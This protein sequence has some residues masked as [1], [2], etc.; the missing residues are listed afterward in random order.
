MPWALVNPVCDYKTIRALCARRYP[1]HPRGCPNLDKKPACPPRA[2]LLHEKIDL[3]L[4]VWA[5]W[6]EY[7]IGEHMKRM[8]G[9]HPKWSDRQLRNPLYWQPAARKEL[10][11]QIRRWCQ[12]PNTPP[13]IVGCP[14]ACGCN[15]TATMRSIG[16]ILDWPPRRTAYQI[17]LCGWTP[18]RGAP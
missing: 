1:G 2:P 15:L 16:I 3:A 4:P 17:V 6:N 9:R 7:P 11:V 10:R 8:A 5:V 18:K 13:V 14:E 12:L